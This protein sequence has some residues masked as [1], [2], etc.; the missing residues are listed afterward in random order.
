VS[1]G[2]LVVGYKGGPLIRICEIVPGQ[3]S[4]AVSSVSVAFRT[5]S[6]V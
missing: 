5:L 4:F 2:G 6:A 3:R 1:F